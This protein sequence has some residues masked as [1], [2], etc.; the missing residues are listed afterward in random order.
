[1][2]IRCCRYLWFPPIIQAALQSSVIELR[3]R[4]KQVSND[5]MLRKAR[6]LHGTWLFKLPDLN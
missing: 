1:V 5:Y 2:K 6:Y 3:M 4:I